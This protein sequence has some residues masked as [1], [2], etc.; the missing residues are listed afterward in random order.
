MLMRQTSRDTPIIVARGRVL[1]RAKSINQAELSF[2]RRSCSANIAIFQPFTNTLSDREFD[3]CGRRLS[4]TTNTTDSLSEE[5]QEEEEQDQEEE[6]HQYYPQHHKRSASIDHYYNKQRNKRI[7]CE[8]DI[9]NNIRK[10]K[11]SMMQ[12]T[13]SSSCGLLLS[14]MT[15]ALLCFLW[16]LPGTGLFVMRVLQEVCTQS[17]SSR[18]VFRLTMVALVKPVDRL[19]NSLRFP[20]LISHGPLVFPNGVGSYSKPHMLALMISRDISRVCGS[21]EYRA[22][23][24]KRVR[25]VYRLPEIY[26]VSTLS[27]T[28]YDWA[29]VIEALRRRDSRTNEYVPLQRQQKLKRSETL[30]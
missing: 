25:K 22:K 20:S 24:L 30:Y 10:S 6:D 26:D 16:S 14:M 1:Q 28:S 18:Y 27:S 5:D 4:Y 3:D 15:R 19:V 17:T 2:R 29:I 7:K 8:L 13:S 9:N 12:S 11:L 21:A 23:R